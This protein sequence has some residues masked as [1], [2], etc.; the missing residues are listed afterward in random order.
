MVRLWITTSEESDKKASTYCL[1]QCIDLSIMST[2]QT[3]TAGVRASIVS[4]DGQSL[5]IP[6]TPVSRKLDG[7]MKEEDV[8]MESSTEPLTQIHSTSSSTALLLAMDSLKVNSYENATNNVTELVEGAQAN[9]L[10]SRRIEE[11]KA[12]HQSN[13][14]GLGQATATYN[15]VHTYGLFHEGK[16]VHRPSEIEKLLGI[17]ILKVSYRFVL[18]VEQ[19]YFYFTYLFLLS[20][21]RADQEQRR[22]DLGRG[23][24]KLYIPS[25]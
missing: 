14:C 21:F 7:Q 24:I 15:K 13:W 5:D 19:F 9:T 23:M 1:W 18:V 8:I 17:Y 25:F 3:T 10:L 2:P 20:L 22:W 11:Y 6:T 16:T 12:R 4:T